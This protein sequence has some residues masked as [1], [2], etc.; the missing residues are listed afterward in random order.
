MNF[1]YPYIGEKDNYYWL[2]LKFQYASEIWLFIKN[3][4]LLINGEKFEISEKWERD[5]NRGIWEW[6]D[7]S[8]AKNYDIRKIKDKLLKLDYEYNGSN[9]YGFVI[10]KNKKLL[11]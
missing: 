9:E 5:H 8:I 7:I 11:F 10:Y 3:G 1:I 6:L 4:T 2:T